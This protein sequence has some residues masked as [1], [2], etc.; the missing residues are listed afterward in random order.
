MADSSSRKDIPP[1][2]MF[3]LY[4]PDADKIPKVTASS[5]WG[6][7][8]A[9]LTHYDICNLYEKLCR[10]LM[11]P[12]L[13]LWSDPTVYRPN[14]NSNRFTYPNGFL[15]I[16][17]DDLRPPKLAATVASTS[18][19][20]SVFTALFRTIFDNV[21]YLDSD[22]P[23]IKN[24]SQNM[25]YGDSKGAGSYGTKTTYKN[26][27]SSS[28]IVTSQE[29]EGGAS[30]TPHSVPEDH[31]FACV[32]D[33]RQDTKLKLVMMTPLPASV[34]TT[35]EALAVAAATLPAGPARDQAIADLETARQAN[36]AKA[37]ARLN[38]A[39]AA[40][41]EATE[42][43]ENAQREY[44]TAA[45]ERVSAEVNKTAADQA[46]QAG[47][48]SCDTAREELARA[49]QA[50][51]EA[52]TDEEREAA[53]AAV[54]EAQETLNECLESLEE[55]LA[56]QQEATEALQT[57]QQKYSAAE[58]KLEVAT[59]KSEECLSEKQDA[60]R[61]LQELSNNPD[62]IEHPTQAIYIPEHG[63]YYH[64]EGYTFERIA[65]LFTVGSEWSTEKL[66]RYALLSF[67]PKLEYRFQGS[68]INHQW[69]GAT[70]DQESKTLAILERV[71]TAGWDNKLEIAGGEV[72]KTDDQP[73]YVYP[74]PPPM[75]TW[76][77]W[78]HYKLP[79]SWGNAP[80]MED[81]RK[82]FLPPMPDTILAAHLYINQYP[83]DK[84]SMEE[85]RNDLLEQAKRW[86]ERGIE[87]WAAAL[88]QQ[89]ANMVPSKTRPSIE[90]GGSYPGSTPRRP[91][92][93]TDGPLI[94]ADLVLPTPA[95]TTT[96]W[97][98]PTLLA[99][100]FK[101]LFDWADRFRYTL[102]PLDLSAIA[103]T[104]N[105]EESGTFVE[106]SNG[107]T[108]TQNSDGSSSTRDSQATMTLTFTVQANGRGTGDQVLPDTEEE[109]GFKVS[110][111]FT[112][113]LPAVSR[114]VSGQAG[115]SSSSSTEHTEDTWPSGNTTSS[116]VTRT[117]TDTYELTATANIRTS[118]FRPLARSIGRVEAGRV[119]MTSTYTERRQPDETGGNGRPVAP[120]QIQRTAAP[121]ATTKEDRVALLTPGNMQFMSSCR[122][123][124]LVKLVID[125]PPD[126]VT[127]Y[128][129][130]RTTN[131]T[132]EKDDSTEETHRGKASSKVVAFR[133]LDLG[134]P[135]VKTGTFDATFDPAT[136]TEGLTLPSISGPGVDSGLAS[137]VTSVVWKGYDHKSHGFQHPYRHYGTSSTTMNRKYDITPG[138]DII[139]DGVSVPGPAIETL[140]S[141]NGESSDSDITVTPKSIT[142]SV[143]C[144]WAGLLIDWDFDKRASI[145]QS[146]TEADKVGDDANSALN[147]I[148]DA[149]NSLTDDKRRVSAAKSRLDSLTTYWTS[150]YDE[151][152]NASTDLAESLTETENKQRAQADE[153]DAAAADDANKINKEN[154][155]YSRL[156]HEEQ[157]QQYESHV[158]TIRQ[159]T[160]SKDAHKT[161]ATNLRSGAD[162]RKTHANALR[163]IASQLERD[164]D[165]KIRDLYTPIKDT[166][167]ELESDIDETLATLQ[168]KQSRLEEIK[169]EELPTLQAQITRAAEAIERYTEQVQNAKDD[170]ARY[171]E[172]VK[173][174]ET[175]LTFAK[176]NRTSAEQR[177][178]AAESLPPDDEDRAEA[179]QE[180]QQA[181]QDA[182]RDVQITNETLQEA[183][184][185]LAQAN[186]K[187][188]DATS[189]LEEAKATEA[190]LMA[191]L[192]EKSD[193]LDNLWD[194]DDRAGVYALDNRVSTLEISVDDYNVKCEDPHF[195]NAA[196]FAQHDKDSKNC[197]TEKTSG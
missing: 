5:R 138:G 97:K 147:T 129:D 58:N 178:R 74:V 36:L 185:N 103:Y 53:Q 85:I 116:T 50:L 186:T 39:T 104:V 38:D 91:R 12:N 90:T 120:K 157:E 43:Y 183:T 101:S 3:H 137:K 164:K 30:A 121:N 132:T 175:S 135:D 11:F 66:R 75:Y 195:T 144:Q 169:N 168:E 7:R 8:Q 126:A 184:D 56:A 57:T 6:Q 23:I 190:E 142:I 86:R 127:Y 159:Y 111:P 80:G 177:L 88:E 153:E 24:R 21:P 79:E 187:L 68:D 1:D 20:Q 63:L 71:G 94:A 136:L 181:L 14:L 197:W 93:E 89:A 82:V 99:P 2:Q 106:T 166:A 196:S 77:Y 70:S 150:K 118:K 25:G 29:E 170:I 40:L 140:K 31:I 189:A 42:A 45:G 115:Q 112:M 51:A 35:I 141:A 180:A 60:G 152:I 156:S 128:T 165:S 9:V 119:T 163:G 173:A 10:R 143:E 134:T 98:S 32:S 47:Q 78:D 44:G 107:H 188:V 28:P 95:P 72:P 64:P 122:M 179:I 145:T 172:E 62:I 73:S 84:T 162:C 76:N 114:N 83:P 171:E 148:T 55:L 22:A 13:K 4:F 52:T 146:P 92:A 33:W 117:S 105:A 61:A 193:E 69:Q 167:D 133:L 59:S 176:A 139:V 131:Y 108:E 192:Q 182:I 41:E 17:N 67:Y 16:S 123:L 102:F 48:D 54:N 49:H 161:K 160:A 100:F 155:R 15:S 158:N 125:I 154:T 18:A 96:G 149:I 34:D 109:A 130:T 194:A 26:A 81:L 113:T 87:D 65:G 174:A 191:E 124:V 46:A 19:W 151:V 110:G 27:A 37:L